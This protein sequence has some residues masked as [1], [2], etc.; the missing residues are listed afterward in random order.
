M[1]AASSSALSG[2]EVVDTATAS[3]HIDT[4][5]VD[6]RRTPSPPALRKAASQEE[7]DKH[8]LSNL[9][10]KKS[11]PFKKWVRKLLGFPLRWSRRCLM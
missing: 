5:V 8:N 4:E 1:M 2:T 11:S 3:E 10:T 7:L 6:T 9:P